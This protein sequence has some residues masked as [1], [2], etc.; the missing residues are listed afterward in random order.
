MK[1]PISRRIL[2]KAIAAAAGKLGLGMLTSCG[3]SVGSADDG[4]DP[5][6]Y[7][8]LV[9]S[10]PPPTSTPT[11]TPTQTPT[12]TSTPTQ[13]PTA[14]STPTNTPTS[15]NTPTLTS[16][17]TN[18]PTATHTP[19][20][21]PS[22]SPSGSRVVHV[23]SDDATFWNGE[24]D[25]WNYVDQSAVD[26]MFD[27]GMMSLMSA[28]EVEDAWQ[29]LLPNYSSD[30]L[31]AIKVNFNNSNACDDT[32]EDI[33]ALIH[34]VNAIVRGL[35]LIGVPESKICIYDASRRIPDRFV[36]GS[37]YSGIVFRDPGCREPISRSSDDPDMYVTFHPPADHPGVP[38]TRIHDLLIDC[39]YLINMP[40]LKP[41]RIAGVTLTFKNHFGDITAPW[42][43]HSY[44]RLTDPLYRSDY[45]PLV[46]IYRNPH[47]AAKTV[48][49]IGD[50]LVASL[51]FDGPPSPW[52]TFAGGTPDSLLFSI[53]PVSI[54]CVMCDLLEA[55][56]GLPDGADDY[57]VLAQQ[58]GL[59]TFE[60]GDP[61]GVGYETI[62]YVRVEL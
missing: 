38:E 47:I 55:E 44:I 12:S 60:R 14:T 31:V 40:I 56:L 41:H 53:D 20:S 13:T 62:D 1:K 18:T 28:S 3:P 16:T 9:R 30:E 32:D 43:L 7:L 29:G 22:P 36:N 48:L 27:Q 61:W 23:H 57:L 6:M 33:D 49:V 21:S 45:S 11:S 10:E 8:P 50:G 26:A 4:L 46:D 35:K 37:L 59:G 24:T 34:P 58:A 15:T 39:T 17:P 52:S 19:Q 25:Y 5:R 51:D 42:N 54:D 2:L